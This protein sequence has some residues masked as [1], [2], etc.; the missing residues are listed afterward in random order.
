MEALA[1]GVP[2]AASDLPV[3]RE[4][5]GD[6]VAFAA[7][8]KAFAVNL[9]DALVYPHPA[10]RAAGQALAGRYRWEAAAARHLA[11]YRNVITEAPRQA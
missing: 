3:L 8:P 10:R 5:F 4:V 2:V 1:A 11:L 9:R 6:A 7:G